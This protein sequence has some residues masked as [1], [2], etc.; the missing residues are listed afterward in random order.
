MS[1]ITDV[2]VDKLKEYNQPVLYSSSGSCNV[3][4]VPQVNNGEVE[5][6]CGSFRGE[7]PMRVSELSVYLRRRSARMCKV[8]QENAGTD[9]YPENAPI[10]GQP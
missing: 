4:H 3:W 2:S 9:D 8:C 6:L 7:N 5:Y 10:E 1:L